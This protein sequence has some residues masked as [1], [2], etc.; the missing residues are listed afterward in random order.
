LP[1]RR[2]GQILVK[3]VNRPV[4]VGEKTVRLR[5]VNK[6]HAGRTYQLEAL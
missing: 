4:R 3:A 1:N 5:P 2:I 6:G